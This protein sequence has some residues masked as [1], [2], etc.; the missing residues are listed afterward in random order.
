MLFLP[1]SPVK[2]TYPARN[3]LWFAPAWCRQPG[4]PRVQGMEARTSRRT[5]RLLWTGTCVWRHSPQ[6][7]QYLL[8]TTEEKAPYRFCGFEGITQS[9]L[10][11][12]CC[13]FQQLNR[14]ERKTWETL[15]RQQ[16]GGK[17]AP[18]LILGAGREGPCPTVTMLG[19]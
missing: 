18:L 16:Q 5:P 14:R 9:L 15:S 10:C 8:A 7:C 11:A 3:T 13:S 17:L 2:S 6:I 1:V 4:F 19:S 12:G